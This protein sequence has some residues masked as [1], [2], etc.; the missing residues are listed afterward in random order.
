[1]AIKSVLEEDDT[2]VRRVERNVCVRLSRRHAASGRLVFRQD[3]NRHN[4][5]AVESRFPNRI[6]NGLFIPE[7]ICS[8]VCVGRSIPTETDTLCPKASLVQRFVFRKVEDEFAQVAGIA[9]SA[10]NGVA[11]TY[12]RF[13]LES[14][15]KLGLNHYDGKRL[16]LT[17]K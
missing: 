14:A 7:H 16:L 17:G 13:L 4:R 5:N 1:M 8:R 3:S 11:R 9:V 6:V 15:C 12:V 2:A 10:F